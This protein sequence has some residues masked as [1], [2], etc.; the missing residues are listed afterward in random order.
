M[1]DEDKLMS[2]AFQVFI[3]E[4]PKH[5]QAWMRSRHIIFVDS[6][7]PEMTADLKNTLTAKAAA[8]G[9]DTSKLI[10]VTHD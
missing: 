5:A 10:H 2:D 3:K 1:G 6:V 9:F 7:S 8:L 4:S